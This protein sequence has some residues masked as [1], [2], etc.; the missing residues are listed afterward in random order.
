MIQ[1]INLNMQR[2]NPNITPSPGNLATSVRKGE[3][4][5]T[6]FANVH[7]PTEHPGVVRAENAAA[8]LK[9]AASRFDSARGAASLLLAAV[10]SALLVVANQVIDTWSEGHLLA[11]WM[12]LWLVAFGALALLASPA[13]RAGVALRSAA[14][15]WT[16]NR[17]RAAED[18]RTWQIALRDPRIM[19]EL[20]HA[21]GIS[22]V[23]DLRR[24]Y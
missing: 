16:E 13:R 3:T 2:V 4:E 11:A 22:T 7:Y 17:R 1:N 21:M 14:R 12:V 23:S 10:V 19:A 5:M 18:E 24:L 6:S 9:S 8:V 20:N 15:S